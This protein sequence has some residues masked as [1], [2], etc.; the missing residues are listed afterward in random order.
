MSDFVIKMNQAPLARC[1]VQLWVC[2][3]DHRT[4]AESLLA[5]MDSKIETVNNRRFRCR[6]L[7]FF[8]F[9]SQ[10]A[11]HSCSSTFNSIEFRIIVSSFAAGNFVLQACISH[12]MFDHFYIALYFT[13]LNVFPFVVM[14]IVQTRFVRNARRFLNYF[15]WYKI[16]LICIWNVNVKVVKQN[17]VRSKHSISE[18]TS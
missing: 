6:M 2:Y 1:N 8:F 9:F 10:D 3:S 17:M 5:R 7:L 18:S 15:V 11:H 12:D 13:C 16:L 14:E 4:S